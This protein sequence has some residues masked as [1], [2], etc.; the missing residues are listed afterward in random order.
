MRTGKQTRSPFLQGFF[1]LL[2]SAYTLT[3]TRVP[4]PRMQDDQHYHT[5][6]R[7]NLSSSTRSKLLCAYSSTWVKPAFSAAAAAVL[8]A[9]LFSLSRSC[10]LSVRRSLSLSLIG[11]QSYLGGYSMHLHPPFLP[12]VSSTLPG[13]LQPTFT[14]TGANTHTHATDVR[15]FV[16]NRYRTVGRTTDGGLGPNLSLYQP[17]RTA[18]IDLFSQRS[19]L[20]NRLPR[21]QP[22]MVAVA[23]SA[24]FLPDHSFLHRIRAAKRGQ[25]SVR[26][27]RRRKEAILPS[28]SCFFASSCDPAPILGG[29][30]VNYSPTT[31]CCLTA[32]RSIKHRCEELSHLARAALS[33]QV[34][35]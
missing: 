19:E 17:R 5:H 7:I 15:T 1:F 30:T 10:T 18:A 20:A 31:H 14:D 16:P 11:W 26:P 25:V 22:T 34:P 28:F 13:K 27:F 23:F 8:S 6:T 3:H 9:S 29:R 2:T 4:R 21:Q 32:N 33:A 12:V 24:L 35:L